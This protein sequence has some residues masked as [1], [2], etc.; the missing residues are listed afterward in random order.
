MTIAPPQ[1]VESS[2]ALAEL[3]GILDPAEVE[4]VLNQLRAAKAGGLPLDEVSLFHS[5]LKARLAGDEGKHYEEIQ[6]AK[7]PPVLKQY[8]GQPEVPLPREPLPLDFA[9]DRVLKA[10]A[11][12]RD[13]AHTPLRLDEL[14]TLLHYSYGIRKTITAYNTK[15]FP[16]RFAPSS[17]GLQATELYLVV[18]SVEGVTKGLYHYNAARHSLELLNQ[19]NMRFK[20][21]KCCLYQDWLAHAG[22][23]LIF[24]SVMERVLWKY[25]ARGYRF[26]HMDAGFVASHA[27]LVAT[28][29]RLRTCAVA[30][31]QDDLVNELLEVDG[32]SEF[33]SLVMPI[34]KRPD[35]PQDDGSAGT[36]LPGPT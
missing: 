13:F 10:R 8:P 18:N 23:V 30:A 29:L 34:G 6:A 5:S 16:V 1:P 26:V 11:S 35:V 7:A 27:Y 21:V 22:V 2:A 9:L 28:A 36:S 4:L 14:G 25:G 12:R 19:G 33:A 17:G 3:L 24:T 32:I 20:V 15:D 31:F